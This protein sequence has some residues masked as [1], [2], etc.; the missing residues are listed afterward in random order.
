M[1]QVYTLLAM[2]IKIIYNFFFF[3]RI[4]SRW[5]V[6]LE[7]VYSH[8]LTTEKS[9][10]FQVRPSAMIMLF[11][12]PFLCRLLLPNKLR[13]LPLQSNYP[14]NNHRPNSTTNVTNI[15]IAR[16]VTT[17]YPLPP[18]PAPMCHRRSWC[19]NDVLRLLQRATEAS[20]TATSAVWHTLWISYSLICPWLDI[21]LRQYATE[22]NTNMYWWICLVHRILYVS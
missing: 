16:I 10:F 20:T 5:G 22:T 12:L 7:G 14:R 2:E 9:T 18:Q 3:R 21:I 15:T 4:L 11:M 8:M 6:R 17:W 1:V 13:L 19:R